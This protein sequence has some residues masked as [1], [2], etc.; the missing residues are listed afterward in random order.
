MDL[1]NCMVEKA[2][3]EGLIHL[4]ATRNIHHRVS[5]YADDV[6]M[7]FRPVATVLLIVVDLLQ[8]FA[9]GYWPKDKYT[10]Q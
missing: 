5:S 9:L 6:V 10:K 3:S 7:F 2:N 8:L 4:L 1:L